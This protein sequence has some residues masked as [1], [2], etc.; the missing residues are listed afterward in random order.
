MEAQLAID[1]DSKLTISDSVDDKP[2]NTDQTSPAKKERKTLFWGVRVNPEV[3]LNHSL[4]K[5]TLEKNPQLVPLKKMHSTLLFVGRK[6]NPDEEIYLPDI[7]K[8][9]KMVIS[10]HGWSPNALTLRVDCITF[11]ENNSLV[12]SFA[13][14]QHI[15]VALAEGTKA[16][17][18][19]KTLMG[20]G[21]FL[22]YVEPLILE[23]KLLKYYF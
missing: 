19:V 15:T 7:S 5:E 17:D 13:L 18:S 21:E 4:I 22:P 6:E 2:Q 10:G 8:E 12:K 1:L 16:V 20:D 9:C 23:G 14:Q 11:M 3:V